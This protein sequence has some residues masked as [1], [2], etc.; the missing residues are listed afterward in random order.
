MHEQRRVLFV[1]DEENVLKSLQRLLLDDEYEVLTAASGEA[2]LAILRSA[3]PVQVVVSDYRMPG[4]N[5]VEFLREVHAHWPDTVR[6][7]LSGYADTAAIIQAINEGR[8]YKFI[9]KPW[10]DEDVKV[11]LA[12]AFERHSLQQQNIQLAK[13]LER[14]NAELNILNEILKERI[15]EEVFSL[16]AQNATLSRVRDILDDLP[17]AVLDLDGDGWITYYNGRMKALCGWKNKEVL[18]SSGVAVL[19]RELHEVV[20]RT[21]ETGSHHVQLRMGGR[22]FTASGARNAGAGENR[23]MVLVVTESQNGARGDGNG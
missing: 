8:I 12:N 13:E 9:S 10:S 7:V 22:T 20:N 21:A 5:G 17:A 6:M 2:G 23:G 14:K 16:K 18:H 1:D 15:T 19:P 3:V 11:S 4:M